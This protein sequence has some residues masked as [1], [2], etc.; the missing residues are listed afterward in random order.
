MLQG[1]GE[2]FPC[3]YMTNIKVGTLQN[4]NLNDLR[5]HPK[6]ADLRHSILAGTPPKPCLNCPQM[7]PYNR[8][9]ILKQGIREVREML[10]G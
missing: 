9:A 3:C 2:L 5:A 1:H 8:K 7:L 6:L 10:R 4:G